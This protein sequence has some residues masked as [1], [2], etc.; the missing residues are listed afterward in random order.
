MISSKRQN[1]TFPFNTVKKKHSR[2]IEMARLGKRF[3]AKARK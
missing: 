3:L 2:L 1:Q